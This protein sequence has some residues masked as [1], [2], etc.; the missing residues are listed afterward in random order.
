MDTAVGLALVALLAA[1][2]LAGSLG[3]VRLVTRAVAASAAAG[4]VALLTTALRQD[5]R[6]VRFPLWAPT[7]VQAISGGIRT[8]YLDGDP[9][10]TLTVT[11]LAPY[12]EVQAVTQARTSQ[13]FGPWQACRVQQLFDPA[14]RPAGLTTVLV[15][16][17]LQEVSI[18]VRWQAAPW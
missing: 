4:Q 7:S 18:S 6:R 9:E 11:C 8:T 12:L 1:G 10:A 14:G 5:A 13:R 3:I 2:L 17:G 15:P 16:R